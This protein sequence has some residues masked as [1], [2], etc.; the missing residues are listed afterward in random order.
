MKT[1]PVDQLRARDVA[2]AREL[3]ERLR[4]KVRIEPLRRPPRT[5]AG[6]DVAFRGDVAVGAASLWSFPALEHLED[7][8][9]R[10]VPAFPYVP[11]YLTFREGPALVKAL[12]GLRG[13]PDLLLFDGQGIAHPRG[14][15]I[16][17]HLGVLLKIPSIG[18]AKSRLVGRYKEP[19]MRKGQWSP[20]K[21][22]GKTVGAVLRTRDGVRPLFVSP[23]HGIQLTDVI[24]IVLA[25]VKK[26]RIPE[27]LRKADTMSRLGG[28]I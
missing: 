22:D 14:M 17:A 5:V 16:A 28:R 26:F 25:C 20:L 8:V 1:D 24:E 15:G 3:Q 7:A 12:R 6:L 23:G 4:A 10:A 19:G 2:E 21:I 11:G 27:P 13:K 18:C 9:A